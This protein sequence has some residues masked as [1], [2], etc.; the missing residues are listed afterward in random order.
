VAQRWFS[1]GTRDRIGAG[2]AYTRVVVPRRLVRAEGGSLGAFTT[3]TTEAMTSS[4]FCA[5]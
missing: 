1:R 2:P 5:V 4:W 3:S